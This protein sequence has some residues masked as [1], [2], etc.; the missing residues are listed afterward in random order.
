MATAT[1]N[2]ALALAG[3]AL[4]LFIAMILCRRAG[5]LVEVPTDARQPTSITLQRALGALEEAARVADY[6][7]Y[8]DVAGLA[9][10]G[11]KNLGKPQSGSAPATTRDGR[12]K[13]PLDYSLAAAFLFGELRAEVLARH[14]LLNPQGRELSAADTADLHALV[15]W[16]N[17]RYGPVSDAY[18]VAAQLEMIDV[19]DSDLGVQQTGEVE[20]AKAVGSSGDVIIHRGRVY[21]QA[22]FAR[23][24]QTDSRFEQLRFLAMDNLWHVVAWFVNR[25]YGIVDDE[26][27]QA[28]Q[29]L[30]AI[31][32]YDMR[33]RNY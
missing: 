15:D 23:L 5:P 16:C 9:E 6:R 11:P 13:K 33:S 3:I 2:V 30:E 10:G 19:I 14:K 29:R 12:R 17:A 32:P 4:A 20:H 31:T 26:F 28:I 1:K 18:S 24:P 7:R 25:G 8:E 21:R 22:S 27:A